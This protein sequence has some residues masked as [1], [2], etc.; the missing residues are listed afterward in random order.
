MSDKTRQSNTATNTWAHAGEVAQW[1]LQLLGWLWLGEQG[2]RQGWAMASGVLAVA[3]WWAV[4]ILLR[5]SAWALRAKPRAVAWLGLLSACVVGLPELLVPFGAA[6][7]G[8]LAVALLW[9]AWS[10]LVETRSQVSTFELGP[11]AWHPVL[12][13]GLV[14]WAWRMPEAEF[15]TLSV[16]FLLGACALV[17]HMA[18]PSEVVRDCRGPRIRWVSALA[19]SAM[20]LMM[21]T[22]W[23]GNAWCVG[24][25]WRTDQRVLAHLALMAGLP[26]LVAL[27]LSW[28]AQAAQVK[29]GADHF[30]RL[31]EG[32]Q[33]LH[34]SLMLLAMGALMLLGQSAWQGVLAMLLPSLAWALHCGRPRLGMVFSKTLSPVWS[35]CTALV[36]G[37]CLLVCV[38]MVSMVQGPAALQA[39][40][41]VLGGLAGAQALAL[42]W[43]QAVPQPGWSNP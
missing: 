1:T 31:A 16:A 28:V 9:G 23:L 37:P 33:R 17:L 15:S 38:G 2:M 4:R 41:A 36:L 22:L 34:V 25:G 10:A 3:L 32:E 13:G 26:A 14:V 5:G 19:P 20:G 27:F 18:Q 30:P 40:M 35:R 8:L 21:G 7:V 42:W 29:P 43:R 12:A 11:V 24:L 6:H 39:A